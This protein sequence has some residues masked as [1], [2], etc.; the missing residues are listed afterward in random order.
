M[1]GKLTPVDSDEDLTRG[2][3]GKLFGKVHLVCQAIRDL[4]GGGSITL[5]GGTFD[6][7]MAGGSL[8]AMVNA[9]LEAFTEH[10]A[11]EMPRGVRLNI[12]SPGWVSETLESMGLDPSDGTPVSIVSHSYVRSR[13]RKCRRADI[14]PTP[15]GLTSEP[16]RPAP[17]TFL[18]RV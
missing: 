4:Q 16:G 10:G 14:P 9:G 18:R 7:P 2:I 15:T 5:T 11:V 12:V 13:R 6:R 1:Y 8:G 17:L 3:Q